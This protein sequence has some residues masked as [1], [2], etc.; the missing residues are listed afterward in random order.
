[1]PLPPEPIPN[2]NNNNNNNMNLNI[3]TAELTPAA[4]ADLA[5]LNA[6]IELVKAHALDMVH[7][8]KR[9]NIEPKS[10]SGL[11]SFMFRDSVRKPDIAM[12]HLNLQ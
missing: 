7:E 5:E 12:D 11:V 4:I 6:R 9:L 3:E 2:P 10:A 1:M 8:L